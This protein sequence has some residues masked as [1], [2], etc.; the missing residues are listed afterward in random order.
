[1]AFIEQE[2]KVFFPFSLIGK[3][4]YHLATKFVFGKVK[5]GGSKSLRDLDNCS[6]ARH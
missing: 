2:M 4:I 3:G 1:M 6:G 5:T